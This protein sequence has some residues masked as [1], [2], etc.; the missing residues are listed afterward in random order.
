MDNKALKIVFITD[1]DLV[2]RAVL[3]GIA[4][5]YAPRKTYRVFWDSK[6][7]KRKAG[8]RSLLA[9][10]AGAADSVA[11]RMISRRRTKRVGKALKGENVDFVNEQRIAS[12]LVNSKAT[13][14]ELEA[15]APDVIV[16]CGGPI[17]R[18]PIFSIPKIGTIN[19]HF[20]ISSSYRGQHTIF[21]PLLEKQFDQVGATVHFIDAGVDTGRLLFELYPEVSSGDDEVSL[22]LKIAKSLPRAFVEM[23]DELGS[24]QQPD[25]AGV[26]QKKLGK[27]VFFR[28]RGLVNS[29]T[30]TVR[31]MIGMDKPPSI[32]ERVEHYYAKR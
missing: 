27:Q 17:L 20:G 30:Y 14:A 13:A 21:W 4:K 32:P 10:I 29:L 25:Q 8:S 31:R 15:L 28:D 9:K 26:A 24:I 6:K 19:I 11:R 7:K 18:E 3:A 22:E 12:Q 2:N 16:V 1:D 23:L 5:S